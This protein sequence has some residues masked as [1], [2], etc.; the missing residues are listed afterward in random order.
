M[1]EKIGKILTAVFL[2]LFFGWLYWAQQNLNPYLTRILILCAINII[3]ATTF[4]LVFGYT[5]QFSLGHAGFVC[6][7]AYTAALLTMDITQKKANFF[8]APLIWPLNSIQ[9]PFLPSLLA[10]G[11][12]A[13]L[14]GLI[15]G[16]PALRLRGDYLALSTLGFAEIIRVVIV[17]LQRVTN[18]ALGLKGIPSYT[19]LLW[20]WGWAIL[21]IFIVKRLG[22][23]SYGRAFKAIREDEIAAQSMGVNLF[24]HKLLAFTIASFLTGVSGG[25]LANLLSTIDPNAFTFFLTFQVVSIVVLG[26]VGSLTGSVISSL[27]YIPLG[28][29]L[30]AVESPVTIA[31]LHIP[32][33]PGMR[34]VAFSIM[35]LLLILFYR[36][37][38]MG[39][40]EFSW[41]WFWARVQLVLGKQSE[42]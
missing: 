26:G 24:Y 21:A 34:M 35:L 5:G 41:Q 28:E 19:N 9:W 29:L 14:F 37:G 10:A 13:A 15:V 8:L 36:K 38:L 32:G 23:S 39:G 42:G 33:I 7:G 2:L 6:V 1:D 3:L 25:L 4:N 18:G 16:M 30:R 31:G 22:D 40:R 17:N 12:V 20:S 27:I 11:S